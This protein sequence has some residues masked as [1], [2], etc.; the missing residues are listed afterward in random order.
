MDSKPLKLH[1]YFFPMMAY[2][3]MI[4]IVDMARLFAGR[5]VKATIIL[6]PLNAAHLSKTIERDRELGLDMSIRLINFPAVEVGL[7][8]GCENVS[9]ITST[10]MA[11]KV[12][13]AA[14]MLQQ[15]FEKLLEEDCPDCLVADVFFPWATEVASKFGI[16]RLV[17]HGTSAQALCVHHVM[18]LQE[19]YKNVESDSDFFTVPD[20]PDTIKLTRRQLPD[21]IRD[22][23][24]NVLTK[25]IERVMEGVAA[26]YG[27]VVN[28][29]R[30]LEP[31]YAEHY[32]KV[33]G[34]KGW[35][36]GPVFTQQ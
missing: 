4:P 19:P 24:E 34:R 23:T 2:G 31:A 26:S 36:I 10:E 9:S 35:H 16:P 15:P 25:L 33:I 22:G 20:L 27:V 6:T 32:R 12:H 1:I 17:F 7:P 21:H 3:H 30:E 11:P 5:G 18:H 14:E 29:F 28:S 8:E 13:K